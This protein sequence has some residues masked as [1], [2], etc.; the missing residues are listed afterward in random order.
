LTR[1]LSSSLKVSPRPSW[2]LPPP[3]LAGCNRR[4]HEQGAR[5]TV[6]GFVLTQA[7]VDG[8]DPEHPSVRAYLPRLGWRNT[9][10]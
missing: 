8:A 5:R 6:R 9:L 1:F 3:S 7:V 2:S 10:G 4:R